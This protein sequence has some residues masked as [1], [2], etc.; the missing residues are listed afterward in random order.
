MLDP[1]GRREEQMAPLGRA[2]RALVLEPCEYDDMLGKYGLESSVA[3]AAY[4]ALAE[5]ST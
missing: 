1:A 4:E 2:I 3:V 5:N